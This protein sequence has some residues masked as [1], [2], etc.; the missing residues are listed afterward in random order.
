MRQSLFEKIWSAHEILRDEDGDSLL[1]VDRHLVHEGSRAAFDKLDDHRIAV[2][3]RD[4]TFGT[5]DHYVPTSGGLDALT[6]DRRAMVETFDANMSR[7]QIEAWGLGH[8]RQGIVHVVGPELG[9]TLPGTIVVCGDSHTSTHGALGAL[10]F[11]IGASEVAHVLATQSIWQRK[12]KAMRIRINGAVAPGVYAKDVVLA[13]IARIGTAGAAGHVVEYAGSTIERMSME[14]RLTVCNMSIEAGAR[15]GLVAPDETT[16]A[17]VEGRPFAPRDEVMASAV[18]YWRN[19]RSDEHAHFDR[20]VT[21]DQDFPTPIITWGITPDTGIAVDGTIPDADSAGSAE[22]RTEWRHALDYMGLKPGARLQDVAIDQ[23]F[24]GSCTNGRI[25]DLRAAARVA[26][27]GR[28]RVPVLV[29]PG[30]MT[31]RM[32]AEA[33]GLDRIFKDAGFQWRGAGCSMCVGMN[34]DVVGFRKRTVST[35]NRNFAGR[36]GVGARTH[37]ASPASAAA[38]ALAGRI[39]DARAFL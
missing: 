3:R 35:S 34:G 29:S 4:Q 33:E 17:Y 11:G 30:S 19:L 14:E 20:E 38:S 25:E 6:A 21:I 13:I 39:A 37:L 9:L 23:V 5:A 1:Y 36:Q 26:R 15:A 12:P 31:V 27:R 24:I 8:R 10:A 18:A 16:F 2:A 7:F 32:Q 22:R 28:A